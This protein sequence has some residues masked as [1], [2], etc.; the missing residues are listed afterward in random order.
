M[1]AQCFGTACRANLSLPYGS[2]EPL[3]RFSLSSGLKA[4]T[5]YGVVGARRAV[6]LQK[7][8]ATKG[9]TD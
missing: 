6:R 8:C 3:A 4:K 2:E 7:G 9:K 5:L 1:E